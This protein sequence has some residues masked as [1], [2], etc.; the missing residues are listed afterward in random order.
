MSQTLISIVEA[1]KAA[2]EDSPTIVLQ[3]QRAAAMIE[4]I[5]DSDE[6][7]ELPPNILNKIVSC[8][9][10]ESL[11]NPLKTASSIIHN[12]TKKYP[13][14][15]NSVLLIQHIPYVSTYNVDDVIGI[16]S[17]FK[18]IPLCEKLGPLYLNEDDLPD[19]DYEYIIEQKNKEID[20]L[21]SEIENKSNSSKPQTNQNNQGNNRNDKPLNIPS[22]EVKKPFLFEKNIFKAI[23]NYKRL[24]SDNIYNS[25]FNM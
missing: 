4:N 12:V 14:D 1:L 6:L 5:C 17:L 21:K 23:E 9:D 13:E 10:F 2:S 18:N 16:L 19:V 8:I 22:E 7:Y 25:H 24:F 15:P 11:N 3:A 20:R